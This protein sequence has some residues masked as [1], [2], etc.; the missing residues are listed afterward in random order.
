MS[1]KL[2]PYD[3]YLQGLIGGI[4]GAK[5]A[6]LSP[7]TNLVKGIKGGL[8]SIGGGILQAKGNLIASKGALLASL[9]ESLKGGNG[10]GSY[11]PPNVGGIL[12][13]NYS[14]LYTKPRPY[15]DKYK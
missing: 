7:V 9:G 11:G 5:T 12:M 4:V 2:Q 15:I 14:R 1:I 10:G 13:N 6:L 3:T 8:L